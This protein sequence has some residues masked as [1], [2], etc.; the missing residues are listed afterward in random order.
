M[1]ETFVISLFAGGGQGIVSRGFGER[2]LLR[3]NVGEQ[4]KWKPAFFDSGRGIFFDG[5]NLYAY[6]PSGAHD[7]QL[8]TA[9]ELS[10][11]EIS[12]SQQ[13]RAFYQQQVQDLNNNR[14]SYLFV[15]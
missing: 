4:M 11:H 6:H 10:S 9:I 2:V 7:T 5:Q 15:A 1:L 8:A 12:A 3:A 13:Q 14:S